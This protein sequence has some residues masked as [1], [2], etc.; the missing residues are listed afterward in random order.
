MSP[1]PSRNNPPKLGEQLSGTPVKV[2][3]SGGPDGFDRMYA[4]RERQR[5]A[6]GHIPSAYELRLREELLDEAE[7][8]V[9]DN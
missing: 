6:R 5:Q 2:V 8:I 3:R 1:V 7:Q 4:E 9:R